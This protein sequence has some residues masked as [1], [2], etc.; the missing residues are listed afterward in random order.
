MKPETRPLMYVAS[1]PSLPDVAY[2]WLRH[3]ILSGGFEEGAAIRQESVAQTLGVS[4]V[5]L[6]EALRRLEV[7]GLVVQRP[8]RGYIVASL[9]PGEIEDIFELR[10]ML[11]ERAGALATRNRSERDIAE[12][13]ALLHAMDGMPIGGPADID[14]FAERN[15]A[16]HDRLFEP[17][18]RPHLLRM[19]VV[20]RNSVE[21]YIRVG[22]LMAGN[23]DRV[24][25]DHSR[26]FD[27]FRRGAAEEVG[28][29]CRLHCQTTCERLLRMLHAK[30]AETANTSKK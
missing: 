1:V 3:E 20:L 22:A 13:E 9:D 2:N 4:R 15:R 8:R 17:C 19:M 11:E 28:E 24:Q 23:I 16:F 7:E 14:L 12:V 6:R 26:I 10:M 29:L 5:P 25:G 21:R 30:R 27:A 18:G